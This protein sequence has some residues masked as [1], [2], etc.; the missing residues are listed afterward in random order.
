[1]LDNV[2]RSDSRF[3]QHLQTQKANITQYK[4][5]VGASTAD[6]DEITQ[7]ADAFDWLIEIC[8]LANE[9]KETA[10]GIKGRFFST[11]VEPPAG[12]FM[13]A[14]ATTPPVPIIAGAIKRSR[15]RDQRFLRS[16]TITEAA[17]IAL[18]LIG[19]SPDNIAPESV[20]PVITVAAAVGGYEFG[21]IVSN[22]HKADMW[23]VLVQRAGSGKWEF[24]QS[25]TGKVGTI[26]V[27]PTENGK[28]EQ[29]LVRVQLRKSNADY[30]VPSDPAYVTI[31]P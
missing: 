8:N 16:Q 31:N 17:K 6:M 30:G 20:K 28:A 5:E 15:E 9:F 4:S 24:V 13:N 10:F 25:G 1:M 12:A 26:K 21:I 11:K 29:I 18:D 7:D 23:N 3:L 2:Y 22:R 14:P 27:T 19:D